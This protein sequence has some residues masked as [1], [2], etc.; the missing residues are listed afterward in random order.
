MGKPFI[1]KTNQQS[2]KFLLKQRVGIPAQHKWITK[3]LGYSFLM[4]YRKGDENKVANA[5]S[6]R[7]LDPSSSLSLL[8]HAHT[9][10]SLTLSLAAP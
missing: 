4:E 8:E 7:L 3:F 6:R 10:S 5:L 2:L 9:S 1:I